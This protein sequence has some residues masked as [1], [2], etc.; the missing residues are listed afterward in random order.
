MRGSRHDSPARRLQATVGDGPCRG[1]KRE[2]EATRECKTQF[3]FETVNVP[4]MNASSRTRGIVIDS[5]DGV[6][7]MV[8]IYEGA[9]PHHFPHHIGRP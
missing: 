4:A 9:S 8:P 3:M 2:A 1:G 7:H 6:F 5:G